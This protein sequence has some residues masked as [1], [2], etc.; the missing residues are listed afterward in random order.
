MK[1]YA[2]LLIIAIALIGCENSTL[3]LSSTNIHIH[4]DE[5]QKLT[6]SGASGNV[7]WKTSN[8]YIASVED[9]VV[10]GNHIGDCVITAESNGATA[11]CRVAVSPK[12]YTYREPLLNWGISF[13]ELQEYKGKYDS[14]ATNNGKKIYY[15]LQ[16]E[17]NGIIEVYTF[18]NGV[19]ENSSMMLNTK[20]SDVSEFLLERYQFL[21]YDEDSKYIGFINSMELESATLGVGLK[22]VTNKSGTY[23]LVLYFPYSNRE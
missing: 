19:L 22:T 15:Y 20:N 10:T 2:Y 16:D 11:Y 13:E 17:D 18:G 7:I 3:I 9:G 1:H 4:H 8:N 23:F 5:R 14:Y 12:Y 21:S 6:I